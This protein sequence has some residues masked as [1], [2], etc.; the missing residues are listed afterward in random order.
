MYNFFVAMLD[1]SIDSS[2]QL[3]YQW[4]VKELYCF[5][6]LRGGAY[7]QNPIKLILYDT[8]GQGSLWPSGQGW[9]LLNLLL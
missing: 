3:R 2:T 9:H 1:L 8:H 4:E 6:T 7:D 5:H